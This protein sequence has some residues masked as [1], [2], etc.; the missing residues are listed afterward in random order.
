MGSTIKRPMA[1]A[2]RVPR[3]RRTVTVLFADVVGSSES[4]PKSDLEAGYAKISPAVE[5]TVAVVERHGGTVNK[6]L[7]DGVMATFG[8][9]VMMEDHAIRACR[10]AIAIQATLTEMRGANATVKMRIGINSGP[11]LI[12]EDFEGGQSSY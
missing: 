12:T 5:A 3:D 10:C 8:A 6:L 4:T 2:R 1:I 11:A 9:P 7:G